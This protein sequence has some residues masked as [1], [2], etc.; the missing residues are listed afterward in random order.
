MRCD[1]PFCIGRKIPLSESAAPKEMN[2]QAGH[3]GCRVSGT[4]F[5]Q[6]RVQRT[7]NHSVEQC[8]N[9]RAALGCCRSECAA[10][11]RNGKRRGGPTM[12]HK[13]TELNCLRYTIASQESRFIEYRCKVKLPNLTNDNSKKRSL[14]KA[15]Q[16][17]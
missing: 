4:P 5:P 15:A 7:A 2:G 1:A 10:R 6:I 14:H 11:V 8:V 16:S 12:S 3:Q 13:D 9:R 17:T